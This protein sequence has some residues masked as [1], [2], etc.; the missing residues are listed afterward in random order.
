MLRK[1]CALLDAGTVINKARRNAHDDGD[2]QAVARQKTTAAVPAYLKGRVKRDKALPVP[3]LAPQQREDE[4][5]RATVAFVLGLEEAGMEYAGL[6]R[7]LREEMLGYMT[8]AY[9]DKGS[10]GHGQQQQ[11]WGQE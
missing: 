1:A 7:E 2:A 6:P 11:A 4:Q 9:M 5:L 3:E 10:A 8:H